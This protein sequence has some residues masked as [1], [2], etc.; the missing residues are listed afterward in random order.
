MFVDFQDAGPDA[1]RDADLCIVGAGAAGIALAREFIGRAGR[2]LLIE[3][4]GASREAATDDLYRATMAPG[5]KP[6]LGVHEGRARVFGGTTTLWGG[7]ARPLAPIDF[8]AR[9]W[10]MDSGW[11]F[12]GAE[13]LAYHQRAGAILGLRDVDFDEDLHGVFGVPRPGF[14]PGIVEHIYSRWAPQPNFAIMYQRALAAAENVCV[15]R[16]ANVS[17]LLLAADG[18]R[19]EGVE[20]RALGG[21]TTTVRAKVYVVC[22]GGIETARLLLASNRTQPAGVGNRHDLVGRYFQDHLSVRWA[23]FVPTDRARIDALFNS[24]FRGRTK[25]YPLLAASEAFQRRRR[26]LNISAA[27][28]MDTP[29]D[30]GLEVVRRVFRTARE[31]RWKD[32]AGAE[33]ARLLTRAPE[34]VRAAGRILVRRRSY[35][36]PRAALYLGSTIE[37][38]PDARSRVTLGAE[39]DAL[40][41]PRAVVDWRLTPLVRQTLAAFAEEVSAEFARVGLGRVAPYPWVWQEDGPWA[42]QMHDV[43]HHIGTARMHTDPRRGVV[44]ADCRVHGVDNLYLASSAVFPTGGHSNPTFT[45]LLLCFRLADRLKGLLR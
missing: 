5:G 14:D 1:L 32:L 6:H 42:E 39:T 4:G 24:F 21:K 35:A 27:V 16:R 38:E 18:S 40:G 2:V 20:L 29:P 12:S 28:V 30:S 13:L 34:I 36:D 8:E 7:Q 31:R 44:D 37:Q 17:Q 9:D 15:V 10:V 45:L 19:L 3:G 41:M 26:T 33:T 22:A 43:Y 11:P 25:Y 23:D